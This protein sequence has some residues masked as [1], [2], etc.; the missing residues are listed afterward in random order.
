MDWSKSAEAI[1]NQRRGMTPWPGLH[2]GGLKILR[3]KPVDD[4]KKTGPGTVIRVVSGEGPVVECADRAL[5]L[6]EVQPEGKKP[7]TAWSWWQ[8]ARLKLGDHL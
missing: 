4:A 1:N 2:S 6:L 5:A 8:G 3:A 7:M